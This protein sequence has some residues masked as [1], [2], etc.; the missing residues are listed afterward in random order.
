MPR[1]K[2]LSH[3]PARY[4]EIIQGCA[5]RGERCEMELPLARARSLRGHF[6]AYIGVLKPEG[7]RLAGANSRT[8]GEDDTVE[9][10][11]QAELVMVTIEH[12]AGDVITQATDSETIVSLVWQNREN[13]WQ[14]QALGG[15]KVRGGDGAPTV[16]GELGDIAARLMDVQETTT[17]EGK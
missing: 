1:A 13:S 12:K 10:A 8:R 5:V 17:G 9:L 4:A 15:L 3:Y 7:R 2:S 14:A 16:S 11:K 6:Y